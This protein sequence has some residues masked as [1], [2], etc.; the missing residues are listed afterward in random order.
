MRILFL[1]EIVEAVGVAK[2]KSRTDLSLAQVG[3][4]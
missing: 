2:R 1:C 3:A 4:V